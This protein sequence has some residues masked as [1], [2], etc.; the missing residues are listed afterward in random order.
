MKK[1]NLKPTAGNVLIEPQKMEKKTNSGIILPDSHEEKTQVG[2]VLVVGA[3]AADEKG[4]KRPSPCKVGDKVVYKEWGGNEVKA[5]GRE[6][7]VI[8]F[9]DILAVYE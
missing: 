5:D 6:Y 1:L 3:E 4:V 9:E 7:L 2:T 8:K